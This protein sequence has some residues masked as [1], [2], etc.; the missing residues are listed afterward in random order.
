MGW[1]QVFAGIRTAV[2]NLQMHA[3]ATESGGVSDQFGLSIT[4]PKDLMVIVEACDSVSNVT[5]VPVSTNILRNGS[6]EFSDAAWTNRPARFFRLR[7][8]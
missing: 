1:G 8:P 3:A 4:G 6:S 7:L 2:W 5:W